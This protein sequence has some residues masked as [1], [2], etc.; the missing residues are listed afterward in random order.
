MKR[1]SMEDNRKILELNRETLR[2]LSEQDASKVVAGI[3]TTV[4]K[5]FCAI[6]QCFC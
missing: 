6:S 4:R 2:A 3:T 1:K 5:S